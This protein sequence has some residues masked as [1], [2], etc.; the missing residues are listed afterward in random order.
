MSRLHTFSRFAEPTEKDEP[1]VKGICEAC[2]R[3]LYEGE[4]V[5]SFEGNL[6]CEKW[7]LY[8]DL[9]VEYITL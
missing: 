8:D 6:Y 9:I 4:I 2:G 7:C 1:K 5:V 3:E